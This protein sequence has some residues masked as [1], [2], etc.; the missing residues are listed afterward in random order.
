MRLVGCPV[1]A[2]ETPGATRKGLEVHVDVGIAHFIIRGAITDHQKQSI[3][4]RV[5][6]EVMAVSSAGREPGA[7]SGRENLLSSVGLKRDLAFQ[8]IDELVLSGRAMRESW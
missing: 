2:G 7:H 5:V 6:D 3:G 1:L 4:R 8:D